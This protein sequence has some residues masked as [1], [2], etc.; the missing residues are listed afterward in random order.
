MRQLGVGSHG[1]AEALATFHQLI[2][3]ALD[4]PLAKIKV[5]ETCFG[6]IGWGAVQN[7]ASS[8]L[9]KHAAVAGWKH[10]ALFFA[11]LD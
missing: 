9:S 10:R 2:F 4:T 5:D 7:L 8:F 3:D 11:V 6:M 1:G